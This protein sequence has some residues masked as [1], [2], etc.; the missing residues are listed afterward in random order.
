MLPEAA[1]PVDQEARPGDVAARQDDLAA[2]IGQDEAHAL[3]EGYLRALSLSE[4]IPKE[5]YLS[6]EC[7][8]KCRRMDLDL[9]RIV[10]ASGPCPIWHCPA[11]YH[12]SRPFSEGSVRFV[13]SVEKNLATDDLGLQGC[14]R[15][16]H[17]CQLI[18]SSDKAREIAGLPRDSSAFLEWDRTS[19][20]FVWIIEGTPLP[21]RATKAPVTRRVSA[22]T[23]DL[24]R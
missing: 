12:D 6:T 18:I 8:A 1:R 3:A 19:E 13:I 2:H 7:H 16:P 11:Q 14:Y 17:H 24:A 23:G 20:E 10:L 5:I 22:H 4:R 21:S 15:K 9:H